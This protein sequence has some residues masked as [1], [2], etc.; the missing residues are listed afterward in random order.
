[1]VAPDIEQLPLKRM[2][3][4]SLLPSDSPRLQ[5][6]SFA[7]VHVLAE[8]WAALPPIIVHHATNRVIDGMH[9]IQAAVLRGE[10]EVEARIYEGDERDAFVLAVRAN[11]GHGL[12][13]SLA[14]RN[15]AAS[16]II[17]L[18][19]DWSDRA[20]ASCTGLAPKTVAAVR[21]RRGEPQPAAGARRGLDGRTRPLSSSEGRLAAIRLMRERPNASL[22]EIAEEA[23]IAPSTVM[24]VRNR[25]ASGEN[26]IPERRQGGLRELRQPSGEPKDAEPKDT[27]P[28]YDEPKDSAPAA[29]PHPV[30]LRPTPSA[31]TLEAGLRIVR[32]D[33][34]MRFSAAGRLLLRWLSAYPPGPAEWNQ[35]VSSV[36][37]HCAA[38]VVDL[39]RRSGDLLHEFARQLQERQGAA[40]ELR[41]RV[42]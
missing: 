37:S 31:R 35:M 14:E 8:M 26:P 22:R 5:G 13:L 23:G 39:A 15:A 2:P 1:V 36:P 42:P 7:H 29:P 4:N 17:A 3:I 28:K 34:S 9:R 25:L 32:T 20:I 27:E 33:P 16:R 40:A 18:Y 24:D 19:P 12:P 30:D 6:L 41:K 21:R 38:L 10:S 11:I